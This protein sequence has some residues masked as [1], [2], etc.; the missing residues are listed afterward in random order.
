[1]EIGHAVDPGIVVGNDLPNAAHRLAEVVFSNQVLVLR[2]EA[3]VRAAFGLGRLD[4]RLVGQP[5]DHHVARRRIGIGGVGGAQVRHAL[6]VAVDAQPWLAHALVAVLVD[7][8][9]HA[10]FELFVVLPPHA[11]VVAVR[12]PLAGNVG[13]GAD[14]HADAFAGVAR[15]TGHVGEALRHGADVALQHGAVHFEAACREQHGTRPAIELLGAVAVGRL[16]AY[17]GTV[18]HDQRLDRHAQLDV[19]AFLLG[20]FGQVVEGVVVDLDGV[21]GR[22]LAFPIHRLRARRELVAER[23]PRNSQFGF[24]PVNAFRP[25]HEHFLQKHGVGRHLP[26]LVQIP[27]D[28][29][30]VIGVAGPRPL[31]FFRQ[32][33]SA[34][35]DEE[36]GIARSAARDGVCRTMTLRPARAKRSAPPCR[37]RP[38]PPRPRPFRSP[39]TLAGQPAVWAPLLLRT[40]GAP[41][42]RDRFRGASGSGGSIFARA[43]RQS[44]ARSRHY[45]GRCHSLD[46]VSPAECCFPL[47]FFPGTFFFHLRPPCL[48]DAAPARLALH[49]T[50]AGGLFRATEN[51]GRDRIGKQWEDFQPPWSF[52]LRRTRPRAEPRLFFVLIGRDA[53]LQRVALNTSVEPPSKRTDTCLKG[54]R[55]RTHAASFP[56]YGAPEGRLAARQAAF[57]RRPAG[58]C[59]NRC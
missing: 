44:D 40:P 42:P 17:D 32:A 34:H 18:L 33:M 12:R 16:H 43:S 22:N 14:A 6:A 24:H 35:V 11:A 10:R 57:V 41:A 13:A 46:E 5:V 51:K 9:R 21:L 39:T 53:F 19:D 52:F 25:L 47:Q 29:V 3:H 1:M 30:G 8:R 49:C 4:G 7:V 31:H 36:A 38:I 50:E 28:V 2:V 55:T 15:R 45:A 59:A 37:R 20:Q 56:S 26:A 48:D 27:H 23:R 54:L 58:V